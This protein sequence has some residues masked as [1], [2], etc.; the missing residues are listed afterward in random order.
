M[1]YKVTYSFSYGVCTIRFDSLFNLRS[2]LREVDHSV[3]DFLSIQK[4]ER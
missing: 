4:I 3:F 1:G 2:W